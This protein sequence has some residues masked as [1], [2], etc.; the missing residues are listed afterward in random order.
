MTQS[1]GTVTCDALLSCLAEEQDALEHLLFKLRE[2][3]L[4]LTAGENRWLAPATSE[5]EQAVAALTTI[6]QRREDVAARVH[7]AFGVPAGAKLSELADH[8]DDE[9]ACQNLYQRQRSLRDTLDQ[10][11]RASRQNRE[12]LASGLATT[13][14]A[15]A[16]LGAVPTYDSAGVMDRTAAAIRTFDARV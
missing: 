6:G 5:V 15:L 11:R 12:L 13:N 2:Q 9:I 3:Q 8:I 4:V 1:N 16:L 14:D 10:V 7:A